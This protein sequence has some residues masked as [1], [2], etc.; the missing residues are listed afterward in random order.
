MGGRT[1]GTSW[2]VLL[3]A[4]AVSDPAAFELLTAAIDSRLFR[5]DREL[6]S[7]YTADSALSR[8]NLQPG[9]EAFAATPELL[10]VMTEANRVH[11]LSGGAFDITVKPLVDLWG[12]GPA[13]PTFQVPDA[14]AITAA[15]A[16][17]GQDSIVI[18]DSAG[19]ITKPAQVTIDLSAIAKG[20]AVDA[21]ADLLEL[22][23]LSD[24]LVEIGGEVMVRGQRPDGQPWR[25]GIETP[26]AGTSTLFQALVTGSDRLAMATSGSYRNFFN[27]DGQRYAHV[28]NPVT[29]RPVTHNLASVTVIATSAAT[30]D[31]WATALLVLGPE[32]GMDLAN[33]LQLAAH[34]IEAGPGN[35]AAA[36]SQA[37][38]RYLPDRQ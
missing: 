4:A 36:H 25:V 2:R 12:F 13:T 9:K 14:A 15:L 33:E 7:T 23:G 31:A 27:E 1:M 24:Y 38:N 19:T 17:L 32:A 26:L 16:N 18:E 30:A 8:L 10:S 20:Y 11:I 28:I 35:F 3:P 5:L 34:F 21:V 6:F 29:G 22:R 37:F